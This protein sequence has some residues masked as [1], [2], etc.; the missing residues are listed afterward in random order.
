MDIDTTNYTPAAIKYLEE[1]QAIEVL[2][3]KNNNIYN[4]RKHR[5]VIGENDSVELNELQSNLCKVLANDPDIPYPDAYVKAGYSYESYFNEAGN[6]KRIKAHLTGMVNQKL[7]PT[8]TKFINYLKYGAAEELLIDATWLLNTQVSL[9]EECR[10]EKQWTQAVRLL[11]DIS[12]H[13]D[14][15]ARVSNR[16]EIE[17]AVDYAAIIQAAESRT[18]SLPATES[19]VVEGEYTIEHESEVSPVET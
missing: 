18:K 19:D 10:R 7:T 17:S 15:D 5:F 6:V 2:Q 1:I 14:V 4:P 16:L 11:S 9:F 8:L 12:Y 3:P 13:V